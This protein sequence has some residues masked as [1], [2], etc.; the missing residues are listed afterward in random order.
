MDSHF[1][2]VHCRRMRGD[3][4]GRDQRRPDAAQEE[5]QS[6]PFRCAIYTRKSTE[7]GL[8]QEFNTLEAQRESAELMFRARFTRDGP[9]S[10]NAMT[11]EDTRAR[12]RS[13]LRSANCSLTSSWSHRLRTR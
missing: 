11:M 10:R 4:M 5:P 3:A 12:T 2:V 13:D 8:A 7:E 9:R 6:S 1:S